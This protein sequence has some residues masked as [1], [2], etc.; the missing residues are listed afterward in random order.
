MLVS[1]SSEAIT[2][3]R[4]VAELT[5]PTISSSLHRRLES[6]AFDLLAKSRWIPAF[7]GMTDEV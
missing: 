5:I 7:V 2:L 4:E 1:L 3:L 6:S